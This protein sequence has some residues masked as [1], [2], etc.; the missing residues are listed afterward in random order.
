MITVKLKNGV[1]ATFDSSKEASQFLHTLYWR[2][3]Q[4]EKSADTLLVNSLDYP[5]LLTKG[6]IR[7]CK[8]CKKV[9][10]RAKKIIC[11]SIECNR[12]HRNAV[13]RKWHK[14][15]PMAKNHLDIR[16]TPEVPLPTVASYPFNV[17]NED[18]GNGFNV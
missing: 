9:L 2:E 12:L 15:N 3:F 11:G 5:K 16:E 8:I 14:K 1:E 10:P 18:A 4:G 13:Q 17:G 6:D 7:K